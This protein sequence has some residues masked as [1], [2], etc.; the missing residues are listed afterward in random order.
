MRH[1]VDAAGVQPKDSLIIALCFGAMAVSKAATGSTTCI[2]VRGA[3]M[4]K[5]T[6]VL[7]LTVCRTAAHVALLQI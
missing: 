2:H 4:L 1:V 5:D 3:Y 6:V 7:G